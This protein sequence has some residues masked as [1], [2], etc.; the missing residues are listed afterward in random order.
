MVNFHK[1][2][3]RQIGT[4]VTEYLLLFVDYELEKL[5][6]LLGQNNFS[7]IYIFIK[8]SDET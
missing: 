5:S 1:T 7:Y 2:I 4:K 3:A 8:N 6:K